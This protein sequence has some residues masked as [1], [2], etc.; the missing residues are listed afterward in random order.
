LFQKIRIYISAA[1]FTAARRNSFCRASAIARDR[2]E[3]RQVACYEIRRAPEIILVRDTAFQRTAQDIV[4]EFASRQN[5]SLPDRYIVPERRRART[6][7]RI[8]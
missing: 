1:F 7:R 4:I 2:N 3:G 8:I 5:Q 6:E